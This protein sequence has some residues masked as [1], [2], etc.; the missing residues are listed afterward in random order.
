MSAPIVVN[1]TLSAEQVDVIVRRVADDVIRA[2]QSPQTPPSAALTSVN[3]GRDSH[4]RAASGITE[5]Q[6]RVLRTWRNQKQLENALYTVLQGRRCGI[7]ALSKAEA[8]AVLDQLT[9]A[10][11]RSLY[12]AAR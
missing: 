3:G 5:G 2:L 6:L 11:R 10:D 7:E 12:S 8:S 4:P 9:P 1:L